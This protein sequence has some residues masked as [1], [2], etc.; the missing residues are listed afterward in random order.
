MSVQKSGTERFAEALGADVDTAFKNLASEIMKDGAL[1]SRDKQLI[2]L[3]C[4]VAVRCEEC[5][6]VHKERAQMAGA[7]RVE[8]LEAAA[9]GGLVRLGSGFNTASVLLDQ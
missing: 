2:A 6:R 5:V 7:S 1:K 9:V 8:M 3:A 4:S